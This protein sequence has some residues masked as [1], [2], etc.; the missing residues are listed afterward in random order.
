[1][2]GTYELDQATGAG[3]RI[4]MAKESDWGVA[5]LSS[6]Y[7]Q[8]NVIPGETLDLGLAT[9]RSNVLR[10]DHMRNKSVRGTQ[11]PGG[12]LPQELAPRGQSQLLYSLLG[13][14]TGTSGAGPYVH[15]IKGQTSGNKLPMFSLEKGFLD[16]ATP[17][18]YSFLGCRVNGCTIDFS[19][20]Q[21]PICNF[22]I[23]CRSAA[24]STN[25]I[26][27]STAVDQTY[28]P[29]T[30]VQVTVYEGSS[31][32]ALGTCEQLTLTVMNSLDGGSFALGSNYRKNLLLGQ[33]AVTVS[34]V[35]KFTDGSLYDKAV[36]GT[37]S[38]VQISVS[39]GTYGMD[40]LLPNIDW[41]PNGTTPKLARDG[42]LS[43]PMMGE[44]VKDNSEATDIKLTITSP[45]S[46][47]N[48]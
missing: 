5:S 15:T 36:N 21:V 47:I 9:Y 23:V 38:K 26:L 14:L 8:L 39:D 44:A 4:I 19:V 6:N 16:L 32:T 22:D 3:S 31:L 35:F 46:V 42:A 33:R 45:E 13:N 28:D 37:D 43:I 18:Y 48:T 17:E 7:K 20:D 24:K 40:F 30:S 10:N 29:F 1:M 11:R 25:S 27:V 41:Y 34:G 12:G 2:S